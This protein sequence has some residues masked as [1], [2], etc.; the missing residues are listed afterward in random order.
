MFHTEN[1]RLLSKSAGFALRTSLPREWVVFRVVT[2][3]L[4]YYWV[5]CARCVTPPTAIPQCHLARLQ[6]PVAGVFTGQGQATAGN[7]RANKGIARNP[8][9]PRAIPTF[10]SAPAA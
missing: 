10:V 7:T 6:W 5:L 3:K 8:P 2:G 1:A 9:I 4:T